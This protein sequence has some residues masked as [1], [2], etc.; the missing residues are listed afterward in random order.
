ME[1]STFY[2]ITFQKWIVKEFGNKFKIRST[3]FRNEFKNSKIFPFSAKLTILR[4]ARMRATNVAKTEHLQPKDEI[5]PEQN[6]IYNWH[7]NQDQS[8]QAVKII[9]AKDGSDFLRNSRVH[10]EKIEPHAWLS[11]VTYGK[12]GLHSYAFPKRTCSCPIRK[13]NTSFDSK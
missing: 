12:I 5:N 8:N 6:I 13:A 1:V 2:I 7:I 9:K 4:L 3:F 10:S 11:F